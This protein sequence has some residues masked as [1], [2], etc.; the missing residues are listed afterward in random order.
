[1]APA[2]GRLPILRVLAYA[3]LFYGSFVHNLLC[4]PEAEESCAGEFRS[5]YLGYDSGL[6]MNRIAH[7]PAGA[8]GLS[9]WDERSGLESSYRSQ[10]GLQG[11]LL[12]KVP[13]GEMSVPQF[14]V[15]AANVFG[16]L[17]AVMLALFFA[18][19]VSRL[20]STAADV[21]AI[22][23]ACVPILLPF[24]PSLYWA[25]FL[26][27]A[28]F[29]AAWM[30]TPW[31]SQTRRRFIMLL[32]AIAGL[33][34]VKCLCG[35]EYVTTVILAPV[36]A[37]T[38]H[39][40]VACEG[41]RQWLGRSAAIWAAG[42]VGFCVAFA[43][44]AR[45]IEQETGED[46]VAVIMQ[47]AAHRTG[48]EDS[49]KEVGYIVLAPDP[50]FL[51]E[52]VRG[53]VRYFANYF[54][55]PATA[56]PQTWGS[57]RF[58]LS[59]GI[60]LLAGTGLGI[61]GLTIRRRLPREAV[62]L[63]PAAAVGLAAALSWQVLAVN[64][65]MVHAHLN[66]IVFCC[67]FLLFVFAGIGFAVQQALARVSPCARLTAALPLL[68]VVLVIGMNWLILDRRATASTQEARSAAEQVEAVL[69]GERPAGSASATL[70]GR[71]RRLPASP[72]GTL[73][74]A[75]NDE[76]LLREAQGTGQLCR[77]INFVVNSEKRADAR[78]A[79]RVVV[80]REGYAIPARVEYRRL[81]TIERA[82]SGMS[83]WTGIFVVFEEKPGDPP[84][85]IFVATGPAQE[86]V[87][88]I[89]IPPDLP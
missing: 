78:P 59:L 87:T 15:V 13:R 18:S 66:M 41:I 24:A 21:S 88:E 74:G 77:F 32:G 22:L 2:T 79:A 47:R 73:N 50:M 33:V 49:L 86:S 68:A 65:M 34:C 11:E 76:R 82:M 55:L 30:L 54:W 17:T 81:T 71:S 19:L 58:A 9:T 27:F 63:I 3:A 7:G 62:A 89:T 48:A 80:I 12:A 75:E 14:A 56:S 6:V 20:G 67:P 36:A 29:L 51:P 5:R 44:H 42:V 46:G 28:P 16:G 53:S 72:W 39:A 26:M 31:A 69:R 84:A 23:T 45:Q 10:Y 40:A 8:V 70:F 1:M 25:P 64:H 85:R 37:L 43:L 60:V 83:S 52:K 4:I 61:A 57:G 38:Y 35:Y